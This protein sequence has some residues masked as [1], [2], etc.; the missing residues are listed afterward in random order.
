[1]HGRR[2]H[3]VSHG[4]ACVSTVS[5]HE[6]QTLQ[7][8]VWLSRVVTSSLIWLPTWRPQ[9]NLIDL[10]NDAHSRPTRVYALTLLCLEILVSRVYPFF[11]ARW[12]V[13]TLL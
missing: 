9:W 8:I 13:L 2:E 1:M 10:W 3:N 11:S 5:H 12:A 7:F 6:Y 4:P